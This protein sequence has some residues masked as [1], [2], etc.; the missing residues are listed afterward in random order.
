MEVLLFRYAY[1]VI[2]TLLRNECETNCVV[3]PLITEIILEAGQSG[4]VRVFNVHI[5]SK[6]LQ[7]TPVTGTGTDLCRFLCPGQV[8]EA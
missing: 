6:L 3:R 5:E 1:D 4:Q 7:R 2:T 8:L